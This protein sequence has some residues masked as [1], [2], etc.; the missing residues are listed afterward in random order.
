[1]IKDTISNRLKQVMKEQ[2]LRQIDIIKKAQPYCKKYNTKLERNDLSQYVSGK[3]EPGQRKIL[4]LA[5]TLKVDPIWLMGF[6]VNRDSNDVHIFANDYVSLKHDLYPYKKGEE[7]TIYELMRIFDLFS[8]FLDDVKDY[9]KISENNVEF[10]DEDDRID[11]KILT[12]I[13]RLICISQKRFYIKPDDKIVLGDEYEKLLETK[14]QLEKL[15]QENQ[16]PETIRDNFNS[17][18]ENTVKETDKIESKINSRSRNIIL[19][20]DDIRMYFQDN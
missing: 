10:I 9:V 12:L 17:L 20:V 5:E 7:I 11:S 8:T 3:T 16:L 13:K 4:V 18:Y 15:F 19:D 6:N 2:N 1:M 14:K